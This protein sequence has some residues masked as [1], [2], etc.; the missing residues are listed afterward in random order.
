MSSPFLSLRR[1]VGLVLSLLAMALL[2]P[3][4]AL[5]VERT[6]TTS[7]SATLTVPNDSAGLGFS[8]SLERSTRSAALAAVSERLRAVIA[9]VQATPG[10]GP[11]D[12][13]TG[14]I[15]VRQ[16][17]RGEKV[18]Y[19]ASEGI[20]V[21][22]HEPDRAGE[23]VSA[24]IAAGA[25][26]VRGP[27]FFVG[28]SETAFAS[29]LAAA[30]DQAKARAT[31]LASRAGAALGPALTIEEGGGGPETVGAPKSLSTQ[32]A[33]CPVSSRRVRT[34]DKC[35]PPVKPGTSTV[36]ATVRVVFALQ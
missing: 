25:T 9:T 11:G 26:G 28:D 33:D 12:V 29:A 31:A 22:L 1:R 27:N 7:G 36:T 18:A 3:A 23:L 5:A 13:T 20:S 16:T 19:R 6:V 14:R 8:V 32:G 17:S 34:P 21:T 24:A 15:T 4:Y 2:V 10:V 35:T 30:F